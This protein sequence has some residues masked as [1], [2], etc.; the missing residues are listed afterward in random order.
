MLPKMIFPMPL[1]TKS[2]KT[3]IFFGLFFF[4]SSVAACSSSN[5]T[6]SEQTYNQGTQTEM[7]TATPPLSPPEQGTIRVASIGAAPHNDVHR[8]TNEWMVLHGPALAYSRL[9]KFETSE[10]DMKVECDLCS[11]WRWIDE[12]TLEFEID[13]RAKWQDGENF[14]TR[15]V[16]AQDVVF[17]LERLRTKGF[18]HSSLLDSVDEIIVIS[19]DTLQI[20]LHFADS[21]FLQNLASPYAV[22]MAPDAIGS[23]VLI[24]PPTGSGPW[25]WS[26]GD[27]GQVNLEAW[28][29]HHRNGIPAVEMIEMIPVSDLST[30]ASLLKLGLV[31]IAQI[32]P[33]SDLI[34]NGDSINLVEVP[35]QGLG[36]IFIFNQDKEPFNQTDVRRVFLKS[37]EPWDALTSSFIKGRVGI[38]IPLTNLAW[39]LEHDVFRSYFKKND[40]PLMLASNIEP[41]TLLVANFG[42]KHVVLGENIAKQLQDSG[43]TVDLEVVSRREYF[44]RGWN[45]RDFDLL[46]GPVPPSHTTNDFLYGLI[47][48]EGEQNITG[49]KNPE[50]DRLIESQ[51]KEMD[52]DL[53]NVFLQKIQK[54]LMDDAVLFMPVITTE[55][56]GFGPRVKGFN[57]SMPMGSGDFWST[58]TLV[59]NP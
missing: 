16:S 36:S 20:T 9:L 18:P 2:A 39:E 52:A 38:G 17:S 53:R 50:M 1:I 5:E 32:E 29:L 47:H 8:L 14:A 24:S 56:W 46:I 7:P 45:D 30:G 13:G 3:I 48:S 34:I 15:P 26:Q 43:L 57:P 41:V 37:L 11:S 54:M 10:L 51:S 40:E 44:Q 49:Y 28:D 21:D 12:L 23:D 55:L 19:D 31:D 4:L 58:V 35:R 33:Y 25:R 22:I 59:E 27:S 42:E 6:I